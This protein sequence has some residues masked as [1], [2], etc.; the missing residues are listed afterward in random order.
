MIFVGNSPIEFKNIK[1]IP[2]VKSKKL[3]KL[4]SQNDYFFTS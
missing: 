2:P 3:S 4:L 1:V